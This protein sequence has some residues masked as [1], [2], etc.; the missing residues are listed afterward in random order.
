MSQQSKELTL[1]KR[2]VKDMRHHESVVGDYAYESYIS[3]LNLRQDT[4]FI[5]YIE[6]PVDLPIAWVEINYLSSLHNSIG[7]VLDTPRQII[8]IREGE[9][10]P[11]SVTSS[12]PAAES[13]PAPSSVPSKPSSR[14]SS[15]S[16]S[17]AQPSRKGSTGIR[18]LKKDYLFDNFIEGPCNAFACAAAR[19]IVTEEGSGRML[20]PLFIHGGSGLGKTHLLHAIG[21]A[22]IKNNTGKKVLYVTSEDFTNAYIDAAN[23]GYEAQHALANF[24]R[25]YRQADVLL[26]DDVQFLAKKTKTQEEFFHTF[27]ALFDSGKQIVLSA[28]CP[29]SEM[30]TM[31]ERLTSRF[32]QGMSVNITRP[33]LETRIAIL[34]NKRQKW[35]TDIVTDETIDYLAH[36]IT[37][38]VR[39]L[40]AALIRVAS[41]A[42]FSNHA[43]SLDEIRRHLQE[44]FREERLQSVSIQDIQDKVAEIFELKVTELCSSRRT[45]KIAHPRQIAMYLARKFTKESLQQISSAF[46]KKDHGTVLHASKTIEQKMKS[47]ESLREL[48]ASMSKALS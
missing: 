2:I 5:F 10:A 22:I 30:T 29:A 44:F 1:W 9:N 20:N 31:H 7:R 26:I 42:S 4:G 32:E 25:K 34:Q 36:H 3:K 40:E 19:A 24:R 33:C 46:G 38:S 27:N 23:K 37:N 45:A 28:D 48:I 35:D 15:K 6:Y 12:T 14:K 43:L 13:T 47:D 16:S 18:S 8:F 41:F 17:K 21:N 39:R 11:L